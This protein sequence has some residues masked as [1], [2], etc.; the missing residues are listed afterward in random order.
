MYVFMH[1][2]EIMIVFQTKNV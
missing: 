2:Y 1:A